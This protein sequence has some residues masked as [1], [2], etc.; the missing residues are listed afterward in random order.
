M[1]SELDLGKF[2]PLFRSETEEHLEKLNQGLL[3]LEKNPND[4]EQVDILLREAHTLK[5]SA[6]MLGFEEISQLSH[7]IEDIFT[8]LKEKKI[9]FSSSLADKIFKA[10]DVIK[11]ILDKIT[12]KEKLELDL[13]G[14]YRELGEIGEKEKA[15][16]K[17][18]INEFLQSSVS[19]NPDASDKEYIRVSGEKIN[20]LLNLV[21]EITINKVRSISKISALKKL[22][23]IS[24][25]LFKQLFILNEQLE[26]QSFNYSE[27]MHQCNLD[28]THIQEESVKLLD[29]I[30]EE[31]FRM[32]P[33][34]DE[35][36]RKVK[37]IRMLPCSTIFD[38]FPRMIRDISRVQGKEASLFIEGADAELDKKVLEQIK[39][40]FIHILRNA[41]D[42]GIELPDE[43]LKKGKPRQGKISIRAYQ[44]GG[45]VNIE[46]EDDGRGI[47][48]KK[49]KEAAIEKRIISAEIAGQMND[50]ESLN[51]IFS[52]GFSTSDSVT[53][54]SGRGVGLDVVK[55][56]IEN[57][58]GGFSVESKKD[59][60]TK[61]IL[62]LP[63]SIALVDIL[64]IKVSEQV[65][66]IPLFFIEESLGIQPEEI[67]SIGEK[68]AMQL[69]GS[70]LALAKMASVLNFSQRLKDKEEKPQTLSV[71]I[72]SALGKRIG[73]I[74]DEILGSENVFRKNLG[75]YLGK[76]KNVDG[77]A[78]LG[79]GKIVVILDA[80]DL[81][82]LA[83]FGQPVIRPDVKK[84]LSREIKKK[85][86]LIVEDSLITRELERNIL[87][88]HGYEVDAAIDGLEALDK[89]AANPPQIVVT[90]IQMP[91]MDGF[92]L[93][94]TLKQNPQYKNIP[95]II[96]TT[97]D[98]D[99]DKKRGLKV[100][101]ESYIVKSG[102]DQENLLG[103][104]ERLIS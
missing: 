51:L 19:K 39:P 49:I 50:R 76:V 99:E 72:V 48:P 2:I 3:S 38:A 59:S 65:F 52:S 86:V 67:Q 82:E 30:S 6:K 17:D 33:V 36:Q 83:Q 37:E 15:L 102:F 11:V 74:V 46:I 85:R 70:I 14:I 103:A 25:R 92:Q 4:L 28:I 53:D 7:R 40:S 62:M 41:I 104:I 97:L 64:L 93:C 71:I 90:D 75:E 24:K 66:G 68:M 55:Q 10:L 100:G 58:R 35:L 42:H 21:G 45:N 91:R 12:R 47:D 26:K 94:D 16:V 54:I 5:G 95:V 23:K 13:S 34:I 96:V 69:R 73:F 1:A 78:L 80:A 79:T 63:L 8:G 61:I 89:I 32:D 87:E 77:V 56:D 27:L 20:K 81:V 9:G 84:S 44:Q 98:S 29:Y 18:P 101:A 88:S 31:S 22:V 43:R 57:L 60:G